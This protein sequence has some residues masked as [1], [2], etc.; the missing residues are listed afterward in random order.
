MTLEVQDGCFGHD[1]ALPIIS[2]L[3]F[4]LAAGDIMAVLGPNGSG[5]T[6]LVNTIVG[7]N[8]WQAGQTLIHGRPLSDFTSRDLWQRLGYVPQARANVFAYTVLDMVLLGRSAHL[9]LFGKPGRS[10]HTD[11]RRI[12]E[13]LQI[14]HLEN[15]YCNAISG[16]ELQLVLIAR[17][18]IAKPSI[19]ILDEP[20]SHLDFRKQLIIL[21]IIERLSREDGIICL[22]NTHF[23]NNALRIA[24]RVLLLEPGRTH[25]FGP[26]KEVLTERSVRKCFGVNAVLAKI[27]TGNQ[28]LSAIFPVSIV[29]SDSSAEAARLSGGRKNRTSCSTD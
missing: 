25:R 7:I 9:G 11:A 28:T 21:N 10:D 12:L 27:A 19:L 8:V 22:L 4:R 15:R 26:A 13:R 6:T 1:P 29:E 20:E 2:D 24:H 23:P 18:L 17:A 14:G 16:G 3:N 5:K